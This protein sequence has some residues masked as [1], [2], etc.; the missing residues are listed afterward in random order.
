MSTLTSPKLS[1]QHQR[2]NGVQLACALGFGEWVIKGIK[3]ANALFAQQGRETLIF[4]G[5]YSTPAK[6]SKW[7]DDHPDFVASQVLAPQRRRA[8]AAVPARPP[9]QPHHGL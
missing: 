4:T 7:L 9:L 8:A 3:K 5:R 1:L 6:V 2:L